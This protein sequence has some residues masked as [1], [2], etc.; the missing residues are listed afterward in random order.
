MPCARSDAFLIAWWTIAFCFLREASMRFVFYPLA[1]WFGIR[2]SRAVVRFAEQG[3]L[4]LYYSASPA[5][6]DS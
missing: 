2:S 6:L 4:L 3:W 1:R 5:S